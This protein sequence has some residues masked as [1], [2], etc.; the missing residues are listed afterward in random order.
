M[1][2]KVSAKTTSSIWLYLLF[3][4]LTSF[5]TYVY[6]Y[7]YPESPFWDEPYHVASAQKYLNNTYFMEQHPPLGKLLIALGEKI[8][9]SN[10]KD[11]QFIDTDYAKDFPEGFSFTGYRLMPTL[12]AWLTAPVFFLIFLLITRS[13]PLSAL[14]S[15]FYIFDNAEI[16]HSRAAMVDSP[17]TFFGLLTVLCFLAIRKHR[18]SNAAV[19]GLS[20]LLGAAFG[21]VMGTKVV[22]LI[23]I[24]PVIAVFLSLIQERQKMLISILLTLCSFTVVYAG[25]WQIHFSLGTTVN[26]KLNNDGYYQASEEYK[27]ILSDKKTSSVRSFPVML[28]DSLKYVTFYNKGVPRLD[29]CKPDENGSPSYLWPLGGRT[30]NYRWERADNDMTRYMYLVPNPAGWFLAFAGLIMSVI[31][32]LGPYLLEVKKDIEYRFEMGVILSMY[33]GYM[34]TISLLGRVMYLYHYFVPLSL[35]FI[36]FGFVLLNVTRI[37][38]LKL[39]DPAKLTLM[40]FLGLLIFA[41]YQIYRPFS[42]YSP[43]SDEG[44]TKR[45]FFGP[46]ELHCVDCEKLSPVAVP[47]EKTPE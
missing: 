41:S 33:F 46:W 35:S 3:V 6:R 17:L 8:T 47:V 20:I 44:V 14:L 23:F 16:V 7:N 40:T 27:Q 22:G 25:I 18:S 45:A 24:I 42:Y 28:R 21:A 38:R 4:I 2:K 43:L 37:W 30:I 34:L 9:D 11:D 39:G 13:A 10:P 31:I 5:F 29:L 12:L 1:V 36:L 15:F 19:F 26:T 32:F